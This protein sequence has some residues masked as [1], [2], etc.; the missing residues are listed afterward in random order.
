MPRLVNTH[1]RI[2]IQ[3]VAW[4]IVSIKNSL[5]RHRHF[6]GFKSAMAEVALLLI[7]LHLVYKGSSWHCS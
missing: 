1:R 3:S 6:A 2:V 4:F 7:H 5:V